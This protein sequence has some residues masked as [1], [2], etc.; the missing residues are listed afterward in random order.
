MTDDDAPKPLAELLHPGSTLMVGT[1]TIDGVVEFRPLTVAR[2]QGHRLEILMD[3]S[4]PWTDTLHDGDRAYVTVSDTRSNTWL[5]LVGTLSTTT[6]PTV[7]DELWNPFAGAYFDEGR[8]TPGITVLYIDGQEGR[9]WAAPS[10]R[11]GSLISMVKAK[12]GSPEES[13]DHG[14][15][16]I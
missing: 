13:G 8:D 12:L 6:D 15:I 9:Y 2:V 4:A 16:K 1:D 11:L 7:I 14:A 5:S 3:T 10:G